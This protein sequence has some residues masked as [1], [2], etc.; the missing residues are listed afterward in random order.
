M[1][2]M[3]ITSLGVL[4]IGLMGS[5]ATMIVDASNVPEGPSPTSA[6][7]P[8]SSSP[9]VWSP[10]TSVPSSSARRPVAPACVPGSARNKSIEGLI[11][12][13][14]LTLV[15]VYL[16]SLQSDTWNAPPRR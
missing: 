7:T 16:V 5:F 4:W 1:P 3:A 9:S 15:A 6:P 8:C 12:G 13:A 11:G 14:V 10:T 2:N